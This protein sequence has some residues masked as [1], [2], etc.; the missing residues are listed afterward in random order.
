MS[1]RGDV[2]GMIGVM[3]ASLKKTER[4]VQNVDTYYQT[5][6]ILK[7]AELTYKKLAF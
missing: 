2:M 7:K 6:G 4:Y 1:Q 5:E 3:K